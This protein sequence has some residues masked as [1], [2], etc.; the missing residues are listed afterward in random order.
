VRD[1]AEYLVLRPGL[2]GDSWKRRDVD[3][4]NRFLRWFSVNII[5]GISI[6]VPAKGSTVLKAR[7]CSGNKENHTAQSTFG[8]VDSRGNPVVVNTPVIKL[9]D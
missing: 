7:W 2:H 9:M 6:D 8:G 5:N 4:A 3:I 1:A